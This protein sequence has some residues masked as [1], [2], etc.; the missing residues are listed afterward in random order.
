MS[1]WSDMIIGDRMAVDNE[2]SSRVDNS[3][4]SRQEWGLIMT[5]TTFEIEDPED[6]ENA[7]IVADTSQLPAMMPEI[8]NVA[9]MDPMSPPQKSDSGSSILGSIRSALG[10]TGGAN[11]SDMDEKIADAET[12][13]SAYARALQN[14]LET[15]GRWDEVRSAAAET[16]D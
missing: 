3:R 15:N 9:E 1:K 6:E 5:A 14:H 16:N 12:L 4:F 11:S 7:T 2:F 13:V 8:E 10:L